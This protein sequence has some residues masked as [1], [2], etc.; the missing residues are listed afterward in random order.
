MLMSKLNKIIV[1]LSLT[2]ALQ[3]CGNESSSADQGTSPLPHE[4]RDIYVLGSST[5]DNMN[6]ALSTVASQN[7]YNLI[8]YARGGEYLYSMCLRIGAFPGTVKF[9]DSQLSQNSKNYFD[10]DWPMDHA[11][12]TFDVKINEN[13]GQIGVD[14]NGYYFISQNLIQ[15]NIDKNTNYPVYSSFPKVKKDSIFIVNLGKNNLLS[16]DQVIGTSQYVTNKSNQCINWIDE[17]LTH[18]IL[19]VGFFTS[20]QP[21]QNLLEKV[22]LVNNSL[23]KTYSNHYFDLKG[24]IESEEIWT[25]TGILPTLNDKKN[26]ENQ[27]VPLSLSKDSI[28]VNEKTNVAISTKLISLISNTF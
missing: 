12:K 13:Q 6:S 17:N 24:Y 11:L 15:K 28:H 22:T 18:N 25:D 19:A 4:K 26:Q 9:K 14:E 2:I 7:N 10:A 16:G 21:S 23:L 5:F 1:L 8:N 3:A 20:T 27:L